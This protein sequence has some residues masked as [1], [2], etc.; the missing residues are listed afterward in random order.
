MALRAVKK[1]SLVSEDEYNAV[2]RAQ[3]QAMN[4]MESDR[5]NEADAARRR[6]EQP[7]IE[8]IGQIIYGF[9]DG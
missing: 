5:R 1:S 8:I 6:Q 7:L 2:Y 3:Q 4:E 9:E